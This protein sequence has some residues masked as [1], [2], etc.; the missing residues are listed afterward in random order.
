MSWLTAN[1]RNVFGDLADKFKNLFR[2]KEEAASDL[3]RGAAE[4][5]TLKLPRPGAG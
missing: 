5:W 3:A 4:T 1:V 2:R